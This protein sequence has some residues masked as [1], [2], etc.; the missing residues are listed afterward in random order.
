MGV[1][2]IKRGSDEQ[3]FAFC[4]RW[5]TAADSLRAH[6][7]DEGEGFD[8]FRYN[9]TATVGF[10]VAAAG[11]ARMLALPEFTEDCKNLPEGRV[12]AGRCDLWLASEDW[13]INWLL[14]FKQRWYGPG[15]RRG[16]VTSLND[17]IKCAVDRDKREANVRWA[18]TVYCPV[19]KWY[20]QSENERGGWTSPKA[21]EDLAAHVDLAFCLDGIMGPAYLLLKKLPGGARSVARHQ[22]RSD[23]LDK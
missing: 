2:V 11:R 6:L 3:S 23:I 13:K 14:E 9:E 18:V 19:D 12:R 8:P 17:A 5:L 10:L 15:S 16:L 7:H 21:L 22:L 1:H 20:E 4:K